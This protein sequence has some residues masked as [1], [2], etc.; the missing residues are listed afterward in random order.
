MR[1]TVGNREL[2]DLSVQGVSL[3]P[4]IGG[5][6]LAISL[7]LTV[8]A[9]N[10]PN[11]IPRRAT[12]IGARVDV[13]SGS[14]ESKRLGFARPEEPFAV[15]SAPYTSR[16]YCVLHLHMYPGQL[17]ALEEL[18]GASDLAFDLLVIG[19]VIGGQDD[20]QQIQDRVQ[21]TVPR[22]QWIDTLGR[23]GARDIMLLE[24]PLPLASPSGDSDD[25][26]TALVKAEGQFRDGDYSGCIASCRTVIQEAGQRGHREA[27]WAGPAMDR[28]GNGR[29]KMTK[30]ERE[31]ALWA[32]LRHYTHLAHHGAGE[33]GGPDFTRADAQFVLRL[34]VAA[35]AHAEAALHRQALLPRG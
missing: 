2:A 34:T 4:M 11:E 15:A 7:Q 21:V 33:G 24:V 31:S 23:A 19:A 10:E 27:N 29:T 17:S 9:D 35:V 8:N 14:D 3:V 28:L 32:V 12:V 20:G 13:H 5:Y 25:V 1:L 30:S 22:S 26:R 16:A 18:R 6:D